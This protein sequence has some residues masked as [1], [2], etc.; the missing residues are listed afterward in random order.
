MFK[1]IFIGISLGFLFLV[2]GIELI[3]VNNARTYIQ[4]QLASHSQDASTS[5]SMVL[6]SSISDGDIVRAET[7]VNA[8]FDRGYY[9]SILI[10]NTRGDTLIRKNLPSTPT[11]LPAWFISHIR[12]ETPPTESM[13]SKG[14]TQLGR[15]IVTSSP[16]L[17]YLQLWHTMVGVSFWLLGFYFIA[18][19]G[20]YFFLKNI[21]KPLKEIEQVAQAI[22]ERDFR[23]VKAKPKT[24]ELSEVVK[25]INTLST[26]IS[27]II[28]SD[29]NT[30]NQLRYEANT[31]ALT[32]LDNRRSFEQQFKN[33]LDNQTD[34]GSGVL[35]LVQI[36]NFMEFNFAKGYISGDSLLK[37]TAS[38]ISST[39]KER[40]FI[41]SR[42][43][44]ATF[45]IAAFNLSHDEAADFGLA[46]CEHLNHDINLRAYELEITFGCGA[47][48]FRNGNVTLG[49][50]MGEADM[51]MLQSVSSGNNSLVLLDYKADPDDG[52]MGSIFWMQFIEKALNED[53]LTFLAQ[54]AIGFKDSSRL[55]FEML[56]RIIAE[57]GELIPAST[58]MP[59]AIRHNLNTLVDKKLI[60]KIFHFMNKKIEIT[61]QIAINL[62]IRSI[63]DYEFM[64]W[65]TSFLTSH[66][67]VARRTVFEFTEFG[68]VEDL[69]YMR[70][71]I[72][73]IRRLGSNFA[74]DNFG[75]H[76]SAF[77][78][79]QTLRPA[80]IKLSPI[81]IK[82][83]LQN[84]ASQ[85]FISSVVSITK[86]LEIG[87]IAHSI[88]HEES[89]ELLKKLG[90]AGY[91]GY[92]T[93]IPRLID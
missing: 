19:L 22:C 13:I 15:V 59:M 18:L 67:D 11:A 41:R 75:L 50:L 44:G 38:T 77:D 58:F 91:Q 34:I 61:G 48:Y 23:I 5:L 35:F 42:I 10:I 64:S 28:E 54:P 17:A 89:L 63:H 27:S 68:F 80:Y 52:D 3:Y 9:Q 78:Y 21:F 51:A 88:E 40:N 83:L 12:L 86:P 45:A 62:S 92:A 56:G 90:V 7:I 81:F 49:G 66:S 43:N 33:N 36:A 16:Q 32:K 87:I 70:K 71:F 93:G 6:S 29:I 73:K 25:A 79:L 14:W 55:Q 69:D 76:R 30:V 47:T 84:H 74:V 53:R 2:A 24:S 37:L 82:D 57:N 39:W 72:E 60:Q 8:M 85:F 31:D 4:E 26:K 65:L 20:L 1:Q 46:I